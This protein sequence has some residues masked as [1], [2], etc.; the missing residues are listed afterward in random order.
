M[1]T[2]YLLALA[3]L[4]TAV[5]WVPR[6]LSVVVQHQ[7]L[8]RVVDEAGQPQ[9]GIVVQWR[10]EYHQTTMGPN[11][12]SRLTVSPQADIWDTLTVIGADAVT[13]TAQGQGLEARMD[14]GW[15]RFRIAASAD[16]R[17]GPLT[18]VVRHDIMPTETPTVTVGPSATPTMTPTVGPSPTA[19]PTGIP[20]LGPN[21]SLPWT[22]QC[23]VAQAA[24]DRMWDRRR[25]PVSL[26]ELRASAV[27]A[28]ANLHTGLLHVWAQDPSTS[29]GA[30][31]NWRIE[32][33][34][35]LTDEFTVETPYGVATVI[36]FCNGV[37]FR[38]GMRYYAMQ[39]SACAL[40][41]LQ[42]NMIWASREEAR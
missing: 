40:S 32:P 24:L 33:G 12:E 37:F 18:I 21:D 34:A 28:V 5:A 2:R 20:T 36:G 13:A 19:G 4:L 25:P 31:S 8:L 30:S 3:L 14:G 39:W 10:N 23:A 11:G 1:I 35:P 42:P 6:N 16:Y 15:I 22:I 38:L 26:V 41:E 17:L 27:W 9:A 29:W 7:L